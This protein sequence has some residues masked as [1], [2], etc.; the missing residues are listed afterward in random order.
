MIIRSLFSSS[1]PRASASKVR[2]FLSSLVVSSVALGLAGCTHNLYQFPEYTFAGRPIPPSSLSTRVMVSL[3][4]NGTGGA[5]QILDAQRDIRNNLSNTKPI[6]S[7]TGFSGADPTTIYSFPEQQRAYVYAN[8]SPYGVSIINYSTESALGSAGTFGGALSGFAVSSDFGR[9]VAAQ[10]QS[11]QLIVIDNLSGGAEYAL[12]IPNV[13]RVFTNQADTVTLA[14]V[15]NSNVI[16]RLVKLN[17]K[18]LPP[19]GAVDCQPEILPVYCAVPVPGTFDRPQSITYSLD[20]STAYVINCGVE[21][22]GGTNGG[23]GVSFI[24]QGVLNVNSIPTSFPYPSVVT[25]TIPI[26]G[27]A[28]VALPDSNN[29]YI[30]GQ[31]LQPDG[32]F[33]GFLTLLNLST[34]KAGAPIPISD[35]NHSKL[36]FAD[37][38]TLWIGSQN[39]ANGERAKQGL[40]YNCLTRFDLGALTAS[41]VPAII[42]ANGS[43]PATVPYPNADNNLLYYG[44]LTGICWVQNYNKVYTAYG[45]QIHAFNTV[46]GSEINNSQ[47]T[48]QGTALD[49]AFM[50][51][52]TNSAN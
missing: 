42:P 35:G 14:M 40:N 24:P 22:G 51:A 11:G 13:Y 33:E 29:L 27:G 5:L 43:S 30:A 6:F 32:L 21:C 12:N 7:I 39:C 49:V 20:G 2:L 25:N 47:I 31:A 26:P 50:D 10:E 9:L 46:D 4:V 16:Y 52:L 41:I 1:A 18:S 37:N 8:A 17:A 34:L 36:L 45:G 44:S 19:P 48:V 28:T 3:T 23:A 15:R 38:N